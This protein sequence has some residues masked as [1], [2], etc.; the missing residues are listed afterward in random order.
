[1]IFSPGPEHAAYGRKRRDF[2]AIS[3]SH[4]PRAR[5]SL[6]ARRTTR[7]PARGGP[8]GDGTPL[9]TCFR[10]RSFSFS[11]VVSSGTSSSHSAPSMV[12]TWSLS[13]FPAKIFS[14][15]TN[16]APGPTA[17]SGPRSVPPTPPH[18]APGTAVRRA[19][20]YRPPMKV[21]PPGPRGATS[22]DGPRWES[23]SSV[24][25]RRRCP[26]PR[27]AAP[28]PSPPLLSPPRPRGP[29]QGTGALPRRPEPEGGG[30]PQGMLGGVVFCGRAGS[31]GRDGPGRE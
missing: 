5:R 3:A 15:C 11:T 12:H 4:P 9:L 8:R 24:G 18:Q 14:S 29:S 1:M 22:P 31:E 25:P 17:V 30:V 20:R 6:P 16:M 13:T 2:G 7:E 10:H 26:S 19:P 28:A 27:R 21:T 23:G